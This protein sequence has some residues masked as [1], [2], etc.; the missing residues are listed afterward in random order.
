[1]KRTLALLLALALL[2]T[3][4]SGCTL[5]S[6]RDSEE[7]TTP[8]EA[9]E[10]TSAPDGKPL[11]FELSELPAIG[12]YVSDD[13]QAYFFKDG[14][15]DAFVTRDDYGGIIPYFADIQMY[16]EVPSY[17]WENP[18]TGKT[19]TE[20][21]EHRTQEYLYSCGLATTDG[22]IITKGCMTMRRYSRTRTA[23]V[24]T[25]SPKTMKKTPC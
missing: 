12:D 21:V 19:E 23:A 6:K 4:L 2:L 16:L 25:F 7:T 8:T 9:P 17:T 11:Y 1:M 3:T 5:F 24:I 22:R 15:H 13:K 14:A 18:D 10:T 20:I